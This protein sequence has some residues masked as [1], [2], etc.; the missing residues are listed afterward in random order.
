MRLHTFNDSFKELEE[1]NM[2]QNLVSG[3]TNI[4]NNRKQLRRLG[5]GVK[6]E[7]GDQLYLR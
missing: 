4:F 1:P 6:R 5:T 2:S 7:C 3:D